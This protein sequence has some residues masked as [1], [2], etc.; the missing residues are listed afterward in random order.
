MALNPFGRIHRK[1]RPPNVYARVSRKAME[2]VIKWKLTPLMFEYDGVMYWCGNLCA[3]VTTAGVSVCT[4]DRSISKVVE[5]L[6][7]K[8]FY[9]EDA[10]TETK[11]NG[12]KAMLLEDVV[13]HELACWPITL[14]KSKMKRV[15]F[16]WPDKSPFEF[17]GLSKSNFLV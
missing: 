13:L 3:D 9:G 5:T 7:V 17:L 14:D 15:D 8:G 1:D 2:C 10:R 4:V 11:I 16:P 12:P 6:I